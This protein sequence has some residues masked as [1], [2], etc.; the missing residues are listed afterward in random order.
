MLFFY[1]LPSNMY[2][3][4]YKNPTI[5]IIFRA[6]SRFVCSLNFTKV[7]QSAVEF[8]HFLSLT[9]QKNF[10]MIQESSQRGGSHR[11]TMNLYWARNCNLWQPLTR[12]K[13]GVCDIH[14][15]NWPKKEKEKKRW[16]WGGR[17]EIIEFDYANNG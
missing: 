7:F 2:V 3:R 16:G 15:C 13:D 5:P 11:C 14:S 10:A 8:E 17:A 6:K 4:I 12:G 1:D 9:S